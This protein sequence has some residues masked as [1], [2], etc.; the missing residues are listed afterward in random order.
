[1]KL[2]K[3]F[4]IGL[5]I[6]LGSGCVQSHHPYAYRT[7][8]TTTVVTT[9]PP[10]SHRE[11][12]RVYKE[13][14]PSAPGAVILEPS[15]PTTTDRTPSPI[16]LTIADNIRQMYD[17]DPNLSSRMTNVKTTVYDGRVTL[18]GTVPSRVD[19]GE[20]QRRILMIPSVVEVNN[21]LDVGVSGR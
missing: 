19:K 6:A 13:P 5:P 14:P 15:N 9:P 20:L 2:S 11:V 4:L 18:E 17:A 7:T 10:T 1:M 3:L 8:P 12:V 16:D 21:K